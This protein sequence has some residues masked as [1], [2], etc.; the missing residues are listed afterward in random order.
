MAIQM[1]GV[2]SIIS[3]WALTDEHEKQVR[4]VQ[5]LQHWAPVGVYLPQTPLDSAAAKMRAYLSR[6]NI[7]RPL[8][9]ARTAAAF[10]S[11]P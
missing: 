3:V 11:A 9:A 6:A 4:F 8:G 10:G 1:M 2:D 5:S 7:W